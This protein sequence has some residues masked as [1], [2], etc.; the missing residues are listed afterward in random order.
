MPTDETG[1]EV[2]EVVDG[3]QIKLSPRFLTYNSAER[4]W[5]YRSV[6]GNVPIDPG[7]PRWVIRN[8]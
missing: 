1:V 2:F 7:D 8:R 4:R 5:Y 3:Q 6:A